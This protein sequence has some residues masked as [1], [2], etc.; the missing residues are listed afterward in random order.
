[1]KQFFNNLSL[2]GKLTFIISLT[3]CLVL[4]LTFIAFI[5][6]Q[7]LSLRNE[8]VQDIQVLS[9]DIADSC[10][11]AIIFDDSDGA[12]RVLDSLAAKPNILGARLVNNEQKVLARFCQN[13]DGSVQKVDLDLGSSIH[14]GHIFSADHLDVV[15]PVTHQGEVLGRLFLRA[16]L[17]KIKQA[18]Y[19]NSMIGVVGF[20]LYSLIAF[21]L[22]NF[23]QRYISQPVDALAQSMEKVARTKDYSQRLQKNSDDELGKL[24]DGFN[25]MLA[26]I[27]KREHSLEK[28]EAHLDYLAH[29]DTL[30][31]LANRLLL[32]VRLEQSLARSKRTKTRLAVL[33]IDLDRFKNINDSFGHNYGDQVLCLIAER[34][35]TTIR[36]ADTVARIGGDE[37]VIIIEQ[38]RKPD[39]LSRFVQRLLR[40]LSAP[41]E[42][43][44]NSLHVTATI[45]ISLFPENGEDAEGLLKAADLAMYQ[46]K[47][48]G[49]NSFKFFTAEMNSAAR[50]N[51]LLENQ[52]RS[53]LIENHFVLH[54]QPQFALKS[55]D[56][57]GFEALLR[58]NDP[59]TGL[60]PPD[61]FIPLAEE[62]GLIVPIGEWVI[63]TACQTLKKLQENWPIPLRMA[64]NISARQFRHDALISA[65]AKALYRSQIKAEWLEL[66]ITESMVMD[67]V[68][69]A[70]NKMNEFKRM[71]IHLA[72]DDFGTG[73][74]SLGYLKKFPISRLKID[75]SF[76]RDL[77]QN[78]SDQAIVNSIIALGKTLDLEIIAEGIETSEQYDFL[79]RAGCDQAQGYLLGRP[80]PI[81][82]LPALLDAAL[83]DHPEL[84][85]QMLRQENF[86]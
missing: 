34:L 5:V 67:N 40:D 43:A 32:T 25:T 3:S 9:R 72:I 18:L 74:S 80:L 26:E 81:K 37:F 64:V 85:V 56:L 21:L 59:E 75:R 15:E 62:T 66:E 61:K 20:V 8:L 22:A 27:E 11:A 30:T 33:F 45:G 23:L 4:L 84:L 7:R 39:D 2:K 24:F 19:R 38:V 65:V 53:A 36:D 58:W 1:M 47:D 14:Q 17:G 68:D 35:K 57:I 42:I 10:A 60:V 82:D 50:E 31:K 55:G 46:S 51:L 41:V 86:S 73:Y 28:N 12:A 6:F 13:L 77:A 83:V 49:R 54:Y 52:L 29:H 63:A 44:G 71:G 78:S 79:M 76:V 16:D 70:I 69:Q 48:D